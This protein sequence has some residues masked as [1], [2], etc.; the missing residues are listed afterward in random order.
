MGE[1]EKGEEGRSN[2]L[3]FA[4]T[5]AAAYHKKHYHIYWPVVSDADVTGNDKRVCAHPEGLEPSCGPY[6]KMQKFSHAR[7]MHPDGKVIQTPIHPRD[8]STGDGEN[9]SVL[10]F[11]PVAFRLASSPKS[12]QPPPSGQ[13]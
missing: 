5:R 4:A 1:G 7:L 10:C 9:F 6:P 12:A 13:W 11:Q 2:S 3:M 8:R